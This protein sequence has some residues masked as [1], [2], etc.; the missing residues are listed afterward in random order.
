MAFRR[1][2]S[3]VTPADDEVNQRPSQVSV[4]DLIDFSNGDFRSI[5][6][7]VTRDGPNSVNLVVAWNALV[8]PAMAY[9]DLDIMAHEALGDFHF[10][11][12]S[13]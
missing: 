3:L 4:P 12:I 6:H 2:E 1:F 5:T 13:V 8:Q 11:P 10:D 9:L 7:S